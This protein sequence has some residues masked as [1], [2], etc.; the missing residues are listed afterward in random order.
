MGWPTGFEPA[1]TSSTSLDS[2][3][4]L[5]PPTSLQ[6]IIFLAPHVKFASLPM[7]RARFRI[8]RFMA[9]YKVQF[10]VFEGPLDLLLYLIKQEEVDI[11]EVNL[12]R[13]ATQFIAHIDFMREL[14]LE[15]AGEFLVMA[16]TLMYIKS[17][18]LL[19]VEQQVQVEGEEDGEDPRW[20]L[21]RQLVEYKKF[22]DAAAQLSV[23][24]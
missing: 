22:K 10:E 12:T 18:E 16:S 5:R 15:V 3:I 1:T 8:S 4:E 24:E 7:P 19:P 2:T 14:D 23:L 9:E 11:Y 20:E 17:R 13:L 21:I 6:R